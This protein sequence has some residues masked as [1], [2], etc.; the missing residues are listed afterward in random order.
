MYR[1]LPTLLVP[2]AL[3]CAPTAISAQQASTDSLARRINVLER[4]VSD[5]EIRIRELEVLIANE[6][7][8]SPAMTSIMSRDIQ[9][10]RQLRAGMTMEQVRALL[11]EPER[12]DNLGPWTVWRWESMG[13]ASVSFDNRSRKVQGWS[14]P[15]W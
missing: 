7:P 13:A 5:L 15:H 3:A 12:V 8:R 2:I 10:W 4:K 1:V 11:G 6:P 9:N 14:E